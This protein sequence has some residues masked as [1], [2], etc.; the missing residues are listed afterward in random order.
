MQAGGR[1]VEDVDDAE[2][3]GA[4]LGGEPQPL[5]LA[6]RERGRAAVEAQVAEAEVEQYLR[7]ARRRSAVIMVA[8][9]VSSPDSVDS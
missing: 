6:G 9:S 1:L 7:G 8:T 3:A 4:Q 2:Q 5:E